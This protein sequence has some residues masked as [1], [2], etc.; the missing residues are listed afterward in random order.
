MTNVARNGTLRL[1]RGITRIIIRG[2]ISV[3]SRLCLTTVPLTN[4]YGSAQG[5]L[6]QPKRD[7]SQ[8]WSNT[9]FQIW[10]DAPSQLENDDRGASPT[11]AT[12]SALP[13]GLGQRHHSLDFSNNDVRAVKMFFFMGEAIFVLFG[14]LTRHFKQ[15]PTNAPSL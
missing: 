8:F 3:S 4:T 11:L 13:T 9:S 1:P 10:T 5:I 14:M 2:P 6:F 15:I 7:A 12:A